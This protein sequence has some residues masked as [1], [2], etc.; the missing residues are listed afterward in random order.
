[1]MAVGD[2]LG[3]AGMAFAAVR[4]L[5]SL[6]GL[7]RWRDQPWWLPAGMLL[8][9]L[10]V[11]GLSLAGLLRGLFGDLS[12]ASLLLLGLGLW[13]DEAGRERQRI[14][15]SAGAA[16]LGVCLYPA[17]LGLGMFDPYRLGFGDLTLLSGL[18]AAALLAALRGY[19]LAAVWLSL[20]VLG[21]ALGLGESTNLWNYLI[22][23]WVCLYALAVLLRRVLRH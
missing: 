1:M 15:L 8:A 6:P 11:D 12:M 4:V 3:L 14:G 13:R 7:G 5:S 10:P 23:P 22:D 16:A 20:A 19:G 18:L 17:A 2:L 21:W 9:L